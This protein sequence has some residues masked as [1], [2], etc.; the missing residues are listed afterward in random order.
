M[1]RISAFNVLCI[2]TARHDGG[3]AYA[4]SSARLSGSFS[5]P[6][7]RADSRRSADR[8]RANADGAA[9]APRRCAA[10]SSSNE[11]GRA[12]RTPGRSVHVRLNVRS[13]EM[14]KLEQ[15]MCAAGPGPA[16]NRAGSNQVKHVAYAWARRAGAAEAVE[17]HMLAQ[18]WQSRCAACA[19]THPQRLRAHARVRGKSPPDQVQ[20]AVSGN[21]GPVGLRHCPIRTPCA[22]ACRS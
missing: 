18:P 13:V 15:T 2:E 11:R 7:A 17:R 14:V 22:C 12:G 19:P 5:R 20:R 21:I 3:S 16:G 6:I 4:S 9:E 10:G 1:T 8:S